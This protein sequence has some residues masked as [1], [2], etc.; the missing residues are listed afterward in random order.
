MKWI[1][2]THCLPAKTNLLAPGNCQK[3]VYI[4]M[5]ST[6][7]A[8]FYFQYNLHISQRIILHSFAC[9]CTE[10]EG[11]GV[12]STVGVVAAVRWS[13]GCKCRNY[14][15]TAW[16][17]V[18]WKKSILTQLERVNFSV[19]NST[20]MRCLVVTHRTGMERSWDADSFPQLA[21][22]ACLW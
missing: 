4:R 15:G 8:H 18:S 11:Y 3:R 2:L 19:L 16:A 21:I 5:H 7:C 17:K 12:S 6:R 22:E 13:W 10:G 9:I 1:V 20:L 14:A